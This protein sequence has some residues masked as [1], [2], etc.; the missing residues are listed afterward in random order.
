MNIVIVFD[1]VLTP[2][3]R[4]TSRDI[5][6]QTD[7]R[8]FS[9]FRNHERQRCGRS[10]AELFLRTVRLDFGRLYI[11]ALDGQLND[12]LTF[13]EKEFNKEKVCAMKWLC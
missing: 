1:I 11:S 12:F 5:L 3:L 9:L 10:H 4:Q 2:S 7:V 8:S 6:Y 13:L